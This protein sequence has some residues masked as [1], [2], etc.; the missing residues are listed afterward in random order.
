MR[1]SLPL[2]LGALV[3]P[4]LAAR[5]DG[6]A[7]AEQAI[8][9]LYKSGKLFDRAQYK[10]VRE[11]FTRRFEERHADAIRAA[12]GDD[13]KKL[14]E[15]LDAHS[16]IK[17][18]FY[19]ALHEKFD[20]LPRALTLFK[21]LWKKSPEQVEKYSNLAV[22][23]AVVW[24]DEARGVYDYRGH[25]VRTKS[26]MP[27]RLVDALD[28]FDY[29][30]SNEKATEG[31][32]KQLPWEFLTFVVD[33]RTPTAEREWAQKYYQ[34]GKGRIASWHQDVPYDH[35]MLKGERDKASGLQPHLAGRDYTL[36]NIRN[37]GGVC[38][39][40]A[41]FAARVGKSVGIP[42]VYCWGESSYR[43]LHAWWMYVQIQ[44][45]GKDQ[46]RFN[47]VSDGRVR[48]FVKDQFYTGFV[49]DPQTGQRILDRDMERR[50]W[51][52]GKDLQGKRHAGL[53]MSAYPWL[54][55]QLSLD[56]KERVAYLDRCLQVSPL[57]EDAWLEFARLAKEGQLQA[58][59]KAAVR[60]H[61]TTLYK[62]F[63]A[64]PDFVLRLVDDLLTVQPD[65][66][67]R[68]KVYVEVVALCE[69]A[70]RADLACAARLKI[71][72]FLG[73]Q[74]KWP[75][76]SQGLI[77]T[78]KKFPNEGRYVPKMTARLQE[79]ASHYKEGSKA[80]ATLYLDLVPAMVLYYEG[81]DNAFISELYKQ[82]MSYLEEN[83]MDKTATTLK[84]KTDLAR[85]QAAA[86]KK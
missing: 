24:D 66:A 39:Q 67:E 36:V 23:V 69:K 11:A 44:S 4:F 84:A 57:D 51:A 79:V 9:D 41:D 32:A 72:D 63:P 1:I 26:K 73:A 70:N 81:E 64:Y 75:L 60:A 43:G 37:H 54:S 61:L 62:T 49:V 17:Q 55:Q 22:A 20:K 21:E 83:K 42:S 86:R 2:A 5:A 29:I 47:L 14:T 7:E 18:T 76:A 56:A 78:I 12:Y 77:Y 48:G 82:A 10:A 34:T 58:E 31:R 3:V 50:L 52:V 40:Q 53:A 16:E 19:T 13:Y 8:V 65:P 74:D 46:I 85:A 15:W 30:A 45:V 38:A 6:P 27:D 68:V 80:L 71:T 28:N 33:H 35:D 25:Q 59:Q